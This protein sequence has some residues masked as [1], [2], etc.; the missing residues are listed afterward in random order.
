MKSLV[1][2]L[3]EEIKSSFDM[4]KTF[5]FENDCNIELFERSEKFRIEMESIEL[6]LPVLFKLR[7]GNRAKYA[8]IFIMVNNNLGLKEAL[9]FEGF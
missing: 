6:N 4:P 9:E 7:E 5:N 3:P 2:K 1:G 8:H